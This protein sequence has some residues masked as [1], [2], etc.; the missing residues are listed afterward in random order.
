MYKK[1]DHYALKAQKEGYP[2]RSVYKLQEIHRKY[3]PLKSCNRALDIGAAPGSWTLYLQKTLATSAYITSIDLNPLSIVPH[4]KPVVQ[5]IQGDF[6]A[7]PVRTLIKESGPYDIILSDAAPNTSGNKGVDSSRSEE[8][9]RQV[10]KIAKQ[11]LRSGGY[12]VAKVFQGSGLPPL[13]SE[14]KAQFKKVVRYKPSAVRAHSF[15]DFIIC[16]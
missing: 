10:L 12:L 2:A 16:C 14:I 8:L 3:L 1:S 15:E 7:N 13:L 6:T 9:L 5:F 4:S 11:N